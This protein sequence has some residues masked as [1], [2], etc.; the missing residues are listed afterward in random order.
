MSH[1]LSFHSLW[2]LRAAEP[3]AT[4]GG[5]ALGVEIRAGTAP[6]GGGGCGSHGDRG[7]AWVGRGHYPLAGLP[8]ACFRMC[9]KIHRTCATVGDVRVL[10]VCA[11]G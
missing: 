5:D 4:G 8:L 3:Q 10:F 9:R 6:A 1:C 11:A 2:V 7:V